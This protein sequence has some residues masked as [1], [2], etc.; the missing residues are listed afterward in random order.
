MDSLLLHAASR[1]QLQT[2]ST[3]PPHSL[4]LVGPSGIGKYTV[5]QQWALL[6]TSRHNINLV[7]PDEKGTLSIETIRTLY[8]R[9]RSRHTERQVVLI[10]HAEAMS[11]EAQN[12]F[13]KLLEEPPKKVTFVLTAPTTQA[14]LPT[15]L[16]RLQVITLQPFDPP[17][18]LEW[19]K[20]QK[21]S[22]ET[23]TLQQLLFMSAGRPGTAIRL[24]DDPAHFEKHRDIMQRAKTLLT[25]PLYERLTSIASLTVNKEDLLSLLEAMSLIVRLQLQSGKVTPQWLKIADALEICLSRLAQNGNPRAQLTRLFT[26]Y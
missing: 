11:T 13:L 25:A 22:V 9:T 21:T 18:L 15:I 8:Q 7:E 2:L 3:H 16:S 19:L 14:L 26:S 12:A 5:A 10:D 6:L 24:L 20:G 1:A 17:T 23:Q 4:L